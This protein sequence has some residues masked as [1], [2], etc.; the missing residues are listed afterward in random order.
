MHIHPGFLL[1]GKR[2]V[3]PI[4]LEFSLEHKLMV[5]EDRIR[6]A[7]GPRMTGV[8]AD[9]QDGN[10][11]W[12]WA[13]SD[14]NG[15]SLTSY[16]SLQRGQ[17]TQTLVNPERNKRA[18][19]GKTAKS[20]TWLMLAIRWDDCNNP[21]CEAHSAMQTALPALALTVLMHT[22]LLPSTWR[23]HCKTQ[24]ILFG[25]GGISIRLQTLAEVFITG[26]KIPFSGQVLFFFFCLVFFFKSVGEDSYTH[27]TNTLLISYRNSS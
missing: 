8:I 17:R 11:S 15:F 10:S 7:W 16:K 20:L 9:T 22:K 5:L 2:T 13:A 14:R 3:P 24:N 19:Y 6:I 18:I 4:F 27:W 25:Q 1:D 26:S 23:I 21:A 12:F